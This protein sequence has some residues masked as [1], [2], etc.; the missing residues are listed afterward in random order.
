MYFC[1]TKVF[2][3]KLKNIQGLIGTL[4]KSLTRSYNLII[5]IFDSP[6]YLYF[7]KSI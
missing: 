2:N 4:N 5:V 6:Q 7:Y 3:L 1:E